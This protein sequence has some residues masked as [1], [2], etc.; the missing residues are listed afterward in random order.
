MADQ[1]RDTL[2]ILPTFN[3][4]ETL[5]NIV[6][7]IHEETPEVDILI[8]DDGSPDGTGALADQLAVDPRIK[9]LH[10]TG[11]LGLGSAYLEG[12]Q[13]AIEQGYRWVVEMDADGSH[14]PEELPSLLES[15][16]LGAGLVIGARWI[17]GGRIENWP[18]YRV[19]ISRV[20]TKVARGSLRSQ[21]HDLTSG[22]RVLETKWLTRVDLS[23]IA[24]DGYGFQVESAWF[25]ERAGCPITEVPITFVERAGGRSKMSFGIVAE[26]LVS[27]LT[28]GAKIRLTPHQVK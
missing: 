22:F 11:K 10:R 21:L 16:Y 17:E 27:V 2:V 15:A 24:S 1:R 25:L 5:S 6:K 9:V 19:F 8:V 28:W 4:R 18:W 7:R 12:F 14:L 13:R 3:E 20:G 23:D 26:A